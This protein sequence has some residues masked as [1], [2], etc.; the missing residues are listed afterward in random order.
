VG[1]PPSPWIKI[2]QDEHKQYCGIDL[3]INKITPTQR[4]LQAG[5]GGSSGLIFLQ[6]WLES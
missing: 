1:W 6:S 2:K 4:S 5:L 3:H